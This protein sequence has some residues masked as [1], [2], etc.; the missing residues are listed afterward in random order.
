MW[1]WMLGW[2]LELLDEE[3][4]SGQATY[5]QCDFEQMAWSVSL[6]VK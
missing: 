6:S 4:T 1:L 5:L 3:G 2:V